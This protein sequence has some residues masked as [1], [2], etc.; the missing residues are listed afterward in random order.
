M[1]LASGYSASRTHAV[2]APLIPTDR[3]PPRP[4]TAHLSRLT[5]HLA[6][7]SDQLPQPPPE[8]PASPPARGHAPGSGPWVRKARAV[9]GPG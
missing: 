8:V 2:G 5:A 4:P 1:G 3:Q 6:M 9:L 7:D